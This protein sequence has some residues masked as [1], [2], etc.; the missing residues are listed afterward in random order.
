MNR[1]PKPVTRAMLWLAAAL[2]SLSAAAQDDT[3]RLIKLIAMFQR[4]E[5]GLGHL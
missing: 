2:L 4:G 5:P 1:L 3:V